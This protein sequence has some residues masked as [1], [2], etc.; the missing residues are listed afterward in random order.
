[1]TDHDGTETLGGRLAL[2]R[3]N[4]L[5]DDQRTLYEHLLATQI[6]WAERS[7]FE[8]R[9]PDGRLIGPFN[10]FLHTPAMARAYTDWVSAEDRHTSLAA[11][12]RQVIILTVGAAWQAQ[13]ELYAHAAVGREAGLTDETIRAIAGEREPDGLSREARA[14]YRFTNALVRDRAVADGLY[15]EAVATLRVQGVADMVQLI[16]SYLATSALLNAFRV[17]AP[18]DGAAATSP[19]R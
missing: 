13:Y 10:A 6:A 9:L 3:P 18:A 8:A 15:A 19:A 4:E 14:A 2:L 11:D 1:M 5:N 17:P 7:G 12:V 16:G